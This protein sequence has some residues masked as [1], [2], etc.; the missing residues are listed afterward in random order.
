MR[1]SSFQKK[2][3]FWKAFFLILEFGDS[4]LSSE[5]T[6]LKALCKVTH[7]MFTHLMAKASPMDLHMGKE[8]EPAMCLE[9][10]GL[11]VHG[12]PSDVQWRSFPTDVEVMELTDAN[13][14]RAGLWGQSH[15]APVRTA[16]PREQIFYHPEFSQEEQGCSGEGP[17]AGFSE[18]RR[19]EKI[20][21][22]LS[23]VRASLIPQSL[24]N[25]S[26]MLEIQV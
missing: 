21:L 16:T 18:H 9:K 12:W 4:N 11:N 1:D 23:H 2:I 26:A 19:W 10:R 20:K 5:M 7:L 17:S 13:F 14:I 25:L 8:V 3:F 15:F 24:K 6:V 22:I